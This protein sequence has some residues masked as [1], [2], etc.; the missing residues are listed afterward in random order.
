M[1]GQFKY[2]NIYE[3]VTVDSNNC[4]NW[5]GAKTPQGYPKAKHPD[6][7]GETLVHRISWRMKNTFPLPKD[8][9]V[10]HRCDNPSCINPSHL[11]SGT[12]DTN[13]KDR[14][15]KGRTIT[16]NTDLTHCKRGHEFSEANT[17][18]RITGTRLCRTCTNAGSLRRHH[19]NKVLKPKSENT[20]CAKG[21]LYTIENTA[22]S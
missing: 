15:A 2:K 12:R 21:H 20:H 22:I 5:T 17:I 16:P 3:F 6:Y 18:V 13:N 9:C 1:P 7:P 4:W 8:F 19:E 10:L 14:A 11:F